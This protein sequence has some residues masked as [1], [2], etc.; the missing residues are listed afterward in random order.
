MAVMFG[1]VCT[2]NRMLRELVVIDVKQE[3]GV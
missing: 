1:A 2:V 3:L